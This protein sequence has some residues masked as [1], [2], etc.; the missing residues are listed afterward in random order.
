[1]LESANLLGCSDSHVCEYAPGI[2]LHPDLF[3]A[4]NALQMQASRQGFSL[5]VASGYRS[6]ERQLEIWNRKARGK[7]PVLD[8]SGQALALD[9]MSERDR[10]LAIL[11]WSA[12]PGASRHHWGSDFDIY[13]AA[14]LKEDEVLQLTAEETQPGGPFYAMYQWLDEYLAGGETAFFRPYLKDCGGVAREPWHL[15]FRPLAD[16]CLTSLTPEQLL[17]QV[18]EHDMALKSAVIEHFDEIY[19]RFVVNVCPPV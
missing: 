1:M 8:D 9:A 16:A 15:S 13:D 10:V 7:R 6:F 3:Q 12:L 11:R 17:T 2:L 14:A 18:S 4:L 19:E 5:E